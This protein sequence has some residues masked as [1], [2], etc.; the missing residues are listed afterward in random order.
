MIIIT[1]IYTP[2]TS[3]Q[4]LPIALSCQTNLTWLLIYWTQI[5]KKK[6]PCFAWDPKLT[7]VT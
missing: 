1:S 2:H 6:V 4:T 3:K 5:K 7:G